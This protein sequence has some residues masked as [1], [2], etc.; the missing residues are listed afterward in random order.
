MYSTPIGEAG[1]VKLLCP[2]GQRFLY[3]GW[4]SILNSPSRSIRWSWIK[5]GFSFFSWFFGGK[6]P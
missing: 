2:I 1:A 6:L 5:G 4:I 3:S